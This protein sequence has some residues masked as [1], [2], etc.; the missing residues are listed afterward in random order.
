MSQTSQTGVK[1]FGPISLWA[2]LFKDYAKHSLPKNAPKWTISKMQ[3]LSF[4]EKR[5][6]V[7]DLSNETQQTCMLWS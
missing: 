5:T 1:N 4:I 3:Y 2:S 6:K 7:H